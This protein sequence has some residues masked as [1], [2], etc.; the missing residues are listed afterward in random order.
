MI[1]DDVLAQVLGIE[2]ARLTEDLSFET[3]EKWDSVNYIKI[4]L[5]VEERLGLRFDLD[6][7]ETCTSRAALLAYVE[8]TAQR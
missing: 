4:M 7:F 8:K 2:R 3:C 1:V 5:S 6:A